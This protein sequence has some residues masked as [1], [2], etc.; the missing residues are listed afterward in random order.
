MNAGGREGTMYSLK[1]LCEAR[2][3]HKWR[4]DLRKEASGSMGT[5]FGVASG[6]SH[7]FAILCDEKMEEASTVLTGGLPTSG[8][9][10]SHGRQQSRWLSS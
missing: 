4:G 10:P 5:R 2:L 6:A 8:H 3:K 7:E 1:Y 9:V